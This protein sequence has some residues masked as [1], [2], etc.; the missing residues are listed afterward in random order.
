MAVKIF[1]LNITLTL[2][3]TDTRF[4]DRSGLYCRTQISV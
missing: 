1:S 3:D 2:R 4:W